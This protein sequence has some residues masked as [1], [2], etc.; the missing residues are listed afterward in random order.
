[1]Q[2]PSQCVSN[3]EPP[4][5]PTVSNSYYFWSIEGAPFNKSVYT[6]YVKQILTGLRLTYYFEYSTECTTQVQNMISQIYFTYKNGTCND[7]Q[8]D[9]K[10]MIYYA[11]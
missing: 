3:Y 5:D 9:I 10:S 8:Y 7:P 4:V 11:S 1:M 6:P 2:T